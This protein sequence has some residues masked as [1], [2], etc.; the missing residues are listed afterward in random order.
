MTQQ[1]WNS[2][3]PDTPKGISPAN[4]GLCVNI[5]ASRAALTHQNCNENQALDQYLTTY[6]G[7]PQAKLS[8]GYR[9][10]KNSFILPEGIWVISERSEDILVICRLLKERQITGLPPFFLKITQLPLPLFVFTELPPINFIFTKL[11]PM[12]LKLLYSYYSCDRY[13]AL[14]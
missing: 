3:I 1:P 8:V 7:R 9:S 12:L 4:R 5:I 13:R 2:P 10:G 6:W 11:P 14:L